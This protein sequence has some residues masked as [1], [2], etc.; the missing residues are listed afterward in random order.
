[1]NNIPQSKLQR[2]QTQKYYVIESEVAQKRV[3]WFEE[4]QDSIRQ[5]YSPTPRSA[6]ELL[7]FE[8]MGLSDNDLPII[9]E[10]DSEIV[11]KSKNNC[12]TLNLCHELKLDTNIVCQSVY[13]KPT[14]LLLSQLDPQLRFIRAYQQIRPYTDYCLERI[15]KVNFKKMMKLAID[16]AKLSRA[17]GNKG[18]GSVIALGNDI[19]TKTHDTAFTEKD[20]SLHAEVNAIR[21]ACKKL[22]K[23]N[24]SGT[25]LF[26][27]CEPCPMCSSLAVWANVTTIVYGA[28][29][30][31]TSDLGKLRITISSKE[32]I[33]QS[34]VLIEVIENVLKDECIQ[35]Y[36]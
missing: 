6:F 32:I 5:K 35:L 3:S 11:W 27:T 26:S 4:N 20:P 15:V 22:N 13:E 9:K 33:N 29:I 36:S 2:F 31:E 21:Q 12:S 19:I 10:N 17:E 8:Y 7:F 25:I 16:E 18:Y 14:Q 28:S 23:S 1:M 24:L 34:P 30:K